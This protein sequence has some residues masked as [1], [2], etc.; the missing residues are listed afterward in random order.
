ME[1]VLIDDCLLFV[2]EGW[3]DVYEGVSV[4]VG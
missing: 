2:V 1:V 3:V 4:S